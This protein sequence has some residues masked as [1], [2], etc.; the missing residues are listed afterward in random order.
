MNVPSITEAAISHL[1]APVA[2][3]P[4]TASGGAGAGCGV[5]GRSDDAF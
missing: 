1:L 2:T 3:P 4:N 5:E